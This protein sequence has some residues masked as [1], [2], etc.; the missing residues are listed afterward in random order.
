MAFAR[1]DYLLRTADPKQLEQVHRESF[2][3][4]T[5]AQ[6]TQVEERLREELPAHE[7][8]NS[9]TPEDLARCDA[10]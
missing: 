10:G 2:A 3:T 8:P 7:Q 1:Y 6:R 9:S 4:L 5:P